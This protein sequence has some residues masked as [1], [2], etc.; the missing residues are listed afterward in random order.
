MLVYG[1]AALAGVCLIGLV[2]LYNGLVAKRQMVENGW[3]DIDVQLRRRSDLIP[4]LVAVVRGYADHEKTTLDDV[5]A[6][7]NDALSAGDDTVKRGA[8]ETGVTQGLGRL[9]ALA[10]AYPDLKASTQFLNLQEELSDTEDEISFARR[11]FNGAVREYNTAT[12]TFPASLIAAPLGFRPRSY[13]EIGLEDR[14]L[15]SVN[16]GSGKK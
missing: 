6:R 15:P 4:S 2:I 1:L 11:F 14:A 5:I 12:E 8:E 10:E 9:L 7:R 13:F 16:L 3:S